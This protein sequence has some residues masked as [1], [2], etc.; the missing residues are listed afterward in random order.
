[1]RNARVT[2]MAPVQRFTQW[3]DQLRHWIGERFGVESVAPALEPVREKAGLRE[4]IAPTVTVKE[5][6]TEAKIRRLQER[7]RQSI[8]QR[9]QQQKVGRGPAS[10]S[11][12]ISI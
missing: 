8:Q 12:G 10:R 7:V 1:M 5:T 4:K 11:R 2:R 3:A 6:P 9:Q